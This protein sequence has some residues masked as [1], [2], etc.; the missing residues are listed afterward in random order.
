M[1][2]ARGEEA[3]VSFITCWRAF[4]LTRVPG[5]VI[6][7]DLSRQ[8]SLLTQKPLPERQPAGPFEKRSCVNPSKVSGRLAEQEPYHQSEFDTMV[9]GTCP[10]TCDR[11]GRDPSHQS[12]KIQTE[13]TWTS[14]K[15]QANS[16]NLI[17]NSTRNR[18][19]PPAGLSSADC[20]THRWRLSDLSRSHRPWSLDLRRGYVTSFPSPPRQVNDSNKA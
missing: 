14:K 10:R 1:A 3:T 6:A 15:F 11:R 5:P 2:Q 17:R 9:C 18:L 16:D 7:G 4:H 12:K 8:P 13:Q 19:Q 20:D